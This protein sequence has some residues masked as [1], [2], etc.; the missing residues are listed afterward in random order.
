MSV[1]K[2]EFFSPSF[3]LS[4]GRYGFTPIGLLLFIAIAARACSGLTRKIDELSDTRVILKTGVD[5]ILCSEG[6]DLKV[7]FLLDRLGNAREMK[8]LIDLFHRLPQRGLVTAIPGDDLY[9]KAFEPLQIAPFSDEAADLDSSL[10][11]CFGKMASNK[12][13]SSRHQSFHITFP[14]SK[15]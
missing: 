4:I 12:S 11:K 13:C 1:G 10:K 2:G 6:I 8:Y 7:G 15:S 9:G 14:L 5:Q 3:T